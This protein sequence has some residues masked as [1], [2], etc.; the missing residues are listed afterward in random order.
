MF[1]KYVKL[2]LALR[3]ESIQTNVI[4]KYKLLAAILCAVCSVIQQS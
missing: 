3:E 4:L 2:N 1:C